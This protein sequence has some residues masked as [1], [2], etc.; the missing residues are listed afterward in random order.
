MKKIVFLLL[1]AF[2]V[3]V[4]CGKYTTPNKVNRMIVKGSWNMAEFIDNGNSIL[5]KYAGVALTFSEGGQ[6]A[7]TSEHTVY[8]SWETGSN[9][10]PALLYINFTDETDS[11]H[12]L[13]DDWVV[14]KLTKNECI[15][16]RNMGESFDYDGSMDRLTLRKVQ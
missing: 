3:L 9:R 14:Y 2:T 5:S 7:T 10:N 16:K 8:G 6:L 13:S 12:V 1:V 15:L 11:L 4:A